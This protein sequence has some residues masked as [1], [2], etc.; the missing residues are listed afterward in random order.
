MRARW[1]AWTSSCL[2]RML[3]NRHPRG[4]DPIHRIDV[5]TYARMVSFG[6]LEGLP[7]ELLEGMLVEVSPQGVEH[8]TM[9]CA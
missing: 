8:A 5:G 9:S 7:I 4:P 2:T 1:G 3:V 6:C